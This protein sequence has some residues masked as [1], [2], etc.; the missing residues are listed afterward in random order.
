MRRQ[1]SDE[2][3]SIDEDEN[4][5]KDED[6]DDEEEEESDLEQVGNVLNSSSRGCQYKTFYS[7][8]NFNK[9]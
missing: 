9:I 5:E 4:E 8:K 7:Y 1:T 6:D 3:Q 2:T